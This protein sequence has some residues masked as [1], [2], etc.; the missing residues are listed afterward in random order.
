MLYI[1]DSGNIGERELFERET[2]NAMNTMIVK[3]FSVLFLFITL[4][5]AISC[6]LNYQFDKDLAI[7][8]FIMFSCAFLGDHFVLRPLYLFV[9]SF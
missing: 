3:R 2:G 8:A 5:S 6:Y 4:S 9:L 1:E 7:D